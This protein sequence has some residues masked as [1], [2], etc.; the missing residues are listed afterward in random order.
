MA[1]RRRGA[2]GCRGRGGPPR[3]GRTARG[4]LGDKARYAGWAAVALLAALT[5]F[6]S[7]WLLMAAFILYMGLEH[8]APLNDRTK[9]GKGRLVFAV[10]MLV[11]F[12]LTFVP[13]PLLR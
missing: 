12:L 13:V 2:R 7:S 5:I 6:F 3:G 4:A 10:V 1:R 8:P 9:L 11:V